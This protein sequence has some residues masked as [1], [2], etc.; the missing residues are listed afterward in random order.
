MKHIANVNDR[1]IDLQLERHA[2]IS[3]AAAQIES[4]ESKTC[5]GDEYCRCRDCKPG[6]VE[7][8]WA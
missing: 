1:L 7:R 3:R 8:K 6:H 2:W 4:Y 5:E